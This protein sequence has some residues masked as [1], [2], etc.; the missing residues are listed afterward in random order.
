ME[1]GKTGHIFAGTARQL[2]G[3]IALPIFGGS[4]RNVVIYTPIHI[5]I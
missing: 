4:E 1:V 5:G 2:W 3:L